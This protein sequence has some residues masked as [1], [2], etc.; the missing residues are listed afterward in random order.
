MK[1]QLELCT[2]VHGAV[3]LTEETDDDQ[4]DED[5]RMPPTTSWC[6]SPVVNVR[7]AKRPNRMSKAEKEKAKK[8]VKKSR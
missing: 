3:V 2:K 4:N 1:M 7:P 6:P 8:D 5:T